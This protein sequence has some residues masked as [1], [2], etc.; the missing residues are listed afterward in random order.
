MKHELEVLLV[1]RKKLFTLVEILVVLSIM[2]VMLSMFVGTLGGMD[3]DARVRKAVVEL[4]ALQVGFKSYKISQGS[5]PTDAADELISQFVVLKDPGNE[6]S[7]GIDWPAE[8]AVGGSWGID[9]DDSSILLNNVEL[10]SE[11]MLLL[12]QL[13]DEGN[14]STGCFYLLSGNNYKFAFESK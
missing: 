4:Q 3:S 12:D 9:P 2:G 13:I 8:T 14:L 10:S 6:S 1:N 11:H 7:I 5:Y